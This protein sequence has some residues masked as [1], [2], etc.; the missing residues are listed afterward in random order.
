MKY[1]WDF[2]S[3]FQHHLSITGVWK[4]D[5]HFPVQLFF[6]HP[7]EVWHFFVEVIISFAFISLVVY[8]YKRLY[9]FL[10]LVVPK[11]TYS[12]FI[13][14]LWS[15]HGIK[16]QDGFLNPPLLSVFWIILNISSVPYTG[17]GILFCMFCPIISLVKFYTH[18]C[19]LWVGSS[20]F[21]YFLFLFFKSSY[22]D[23]MFSLELAG[24][25]VCSSIT[26]NHRHS[27]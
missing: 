14:F 27:S 21:Y 16:C 15:M 20:C 9:P 26:M 22:F 5:E 23:S 18:W 7:Y 1:S 25:K 12:Y 11:G 4:V 3:R 17:N 8:V 6:Q 13:S 24:S 2:S 10:A 19:L